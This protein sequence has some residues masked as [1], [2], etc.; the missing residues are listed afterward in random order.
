MKPFLSFIKMQL[1]VNYGI[2]A[3][4]YRFTREKK[5]LW[6]PILIGAGILV[7]VVPLLA[8][9]TGLMLMVF[10]GGSMIGQPEM[11]LAISF[12]FAQLIILIF[13]IFYIMGTFYFSKDLEML[14]PLPLRPYEVIAGKFAVVM[15]NEYLT[16]LPLLLPPIIIYG[17]GT[18]QGVLYWLKSLILMAVVPVMPLAIASLFVI[19]L[20]RIVNIGRYKDFLAIVG[21]IVLV[22][23]SMFVSMFM[24]RMPE[25]PDDI[26]KYFAGQAGLTDMIG[27]RFPPGIWAVKGLY[28]AGLAGFGYFLLYIAVSA[29]LLMLMLWISNHVFYKALLSGQE[30]RRKRKT[31]TG[32]H[33]EKQVSKSTGPV[34]ALFKREWKLVLR[35]PLYVL[36]GLVGSIMGP[37]FLIIMIMVQDQDPEVAELFS[38]LAEPEIIPYAVLASIGIMFLTA[39][40]NLIVSTAVSREGR[41]IWIAKMIPVSGKQQAAAKFLCGYTVSIFGVL[42]TSVIVYIFFKLPLLWTIAAAIVGLAGA[43]PMTALSLLVDVFHPKLVWNNEQEAMKQNMNGFLGMLLSI[44]VT[45]IIGVLAVTALMNGIPLPGVLAAVFAASVI[46]GAASLFALFALAERKYRE[47]EA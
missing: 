6:E 3:L 21:G 11:V 40:M 42:V 45:V 2:S 16:S 38:K 1:N 13:G 5:K 22:F 39:D 20:M 35:T 26:Q 25:N 41:T 46:L 8:M 33:M 9:Y 15:V 17:I 10:A 24:Q 44:L 31:L 29:A 27:S 23:V 34:L 30:V 36:N 12:V 37:I 4:K 14:V 18:S 28:A 32:S 7:S 47:M 19:V 43:V